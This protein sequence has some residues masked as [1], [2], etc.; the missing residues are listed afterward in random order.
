MGIAERDPTVTEFITRYKKWCRIYRYAGK[1]SS[2]PDE[3]A[4]EDGRVHLR[5]GYPLPDWTGYVVE[6]NAE[7]EF[8]VL[9]VS[10]ERR[11]TPA[12]A[13]EALFSRIEDAGKYLVYKVATSLRVESHLPSITQKWRADGLDDRVDKVIISNDQAKYSLRSDPGVYFVAYSGGIQPYNHILP[14]SYDELDEILLE[15]FP[16]AVTSQLAAE[17]P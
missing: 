4:V 1:G 2:A 17:V 15:G 8:R 13:Q 7:G 14:L 12:E 11:N 10:T 3:P 16:A 5:R 6:T 9:R